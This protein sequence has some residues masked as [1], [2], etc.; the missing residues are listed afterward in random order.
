MGLE[1]DTQAAL[2]QLGREHSTPADAQ[3]A[4][5]KDL[6]EHVNERMSCLG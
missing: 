3:D 6:G 4:G 5:N 1:R 2:T